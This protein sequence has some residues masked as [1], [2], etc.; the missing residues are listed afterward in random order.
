MIRITFLFV[1]SICLTFAC[2][3]PAETSARTD[4]DKRGLATIMEKHARTEI[5]DKWYPLSVD[6][7]DGGFLSTFTYDF[8]PTGEQDKMIVTQSRHVWTNSKAS[9]IYPARKH[10]LEAAHHG[11][12]F[13]RDKMWDKQYGGFHWLV[14]KK[15][16]PKASGQ[17]EKTAYGNAFGIYALAA[18]Y[19]ASNDTAALNL[20]KKAFLWMEKHSHDSV[21]K[22]YYQHLKRDGSIVLRD[23]SVASTAETGYKDQNSSIHLLEA[24]A[25]L[26]QVWPDPLVRERLQ[27]MLVLI[28]DT[29]TH[30]KGYLVLFLTTDWK[31]ISFADRPDSIIQINIGSD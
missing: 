10:H 21:Y 22:G 20:A 3:Q 4:G 23:A 30:P 18:Y 17:G 7:A 5:L 31:P 27:E 6:T 2:R 12:E 13:L 1:I 11:F 29:I 14:D 8:K 16:N 15:G 26:Y 28:R 19:K 9:E 24:L 25:E